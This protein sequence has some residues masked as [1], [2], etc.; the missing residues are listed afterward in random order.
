VKNRTREEG[1]RSKV[2]ENGMESC[3]CNF[4]DLKIVTHSAAE[5]F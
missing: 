3:S 1:G 4:Y 2:A 5:V